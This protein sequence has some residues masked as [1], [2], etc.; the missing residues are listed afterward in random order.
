MILKTNDTSLRT[1]FIGCKK[2]V[3]NKNSINL[4]AITRTSTYMKHFKKIFISKMELDMLRIIL[5]H[6]NRKKF[7]TNITCCFL[8]NLNNRP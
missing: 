8:I 7:D 4:C 6:K 3:I 5:C 2:F 1:F